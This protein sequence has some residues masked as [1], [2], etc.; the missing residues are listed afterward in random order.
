MNKKILKRLAAA[1]VV[2][3]LLCVSVFVTVTAANEEETGSIKVTYL[4]MFEGV[5]VSLVPIGTYDGG[6]TVSEEFK[7]SGVEIRSGITANELKEQA[8]KAAQYA[9]ENNITG[10]IGRIDYDGEVNFRDIPANFVYLIYQYDYKDQYNVRPTIVSLPMKNPDGTN[11][12]NVTAK[13]KYPLPG[14]DMSSAS[15]ILNKTNE[16]DEPLEGAVFSFWRKVYFTDYSKLKDD[17]ETG[18]DEKGTYYWKSMGVDLTTNE[19]GQARAV[20]LPFGGYRFIEIEAP[21]GYVLD[22][23]PYEFEL[24]MH[25]TVKVENGWY[26]TDNGEPYNLTIK[27]EKIPESS[28]PSVPESSKPYSK[29][30]EPNQYSGESEPQSITEES[31]PQTSVKSHEENP[32]WQLTGDDIVKYIVIGS[33]VGVSLV[34]II[35]LVIVGGKKN[36]KDE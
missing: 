19:N 26:V 20:D 18:E 24:T 21:K 17:V 3:C 32:H 27:N 1:L 29:P 4:P 31:F 33:I 10:Q 6:Y 36:K 28:K 7:A 14:D 35:L 2:V 25:G 15:V 22:D 12:Y 11:E 34:V 30:D 5:G 8:E 16:D 13:G 23:K 9:S